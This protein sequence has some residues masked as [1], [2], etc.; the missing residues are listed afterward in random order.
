MD[1][2]DYVLTKE[3]LHPIDIGCNWITS[4]WNEIVWNGLFLQIPNFFYHLNGIENKSHS[5]DSLWNVWKKMECSY[6]TFMVKKV[7]E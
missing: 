6:K 3:K 2:Y 4:F 7:H 1:F 5:N